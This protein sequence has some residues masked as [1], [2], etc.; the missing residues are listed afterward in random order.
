MAQNPQRRVMMNWQNGYTVSYYMTR[1]DQNTW[2][3]V[4]RIEITGGSLK[5]EP[6]GLRQ[7]ASIDCVR[8]DPPTE[9]TVEEWV[10]IYMDVKQAGK[11][12]HIAMFTG[13]A[14][15]PEDDYEGSYRENTLAV[16]SVLKPADDVKLLRGWYAPANVSCTPILRKLFSDVVAP[17][18]IP[19]DLPALK[20]Y[21]VAEDNESKLTMI[22]KIL[23]LIN[24]R[25][26]IMG[27]GTI[28]FVDN[29]DSAPLVTFDPINYPVIETKIKV[30][31][32]MF[33]CPNV[34]LAIID[35]LT[36]IARDQNDSSKLSIQNRGREV[37]MEESS[38][39]LSQNETPAQYAMRRLKEEQRV[40][41]TASY[42]R[43]YIPDLLPSDV[44]TLRYPEQKLN[45][46]FVI[47][48]QS[49]ELTHAARTSEQILE[50]IK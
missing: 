31:K 5:R 39:A 28:T 15:S 34:F 17:V 36:A 9:D 26:R 37:W 2:R 32:D 35:D 47:A 27:D 13:L 38:G 7:S 18:E 14:T 20:T 45:G 43:R 42:D 24:W 29:S 6:S 50:V 40:A 44:V 46:E 22:D 4:E 16:Y 30:K 8:Y 19:D 48:S 49:I 41:R 10:R 11:S 25:M 12:D 21:I 3:D 23:N 1:I 33:D